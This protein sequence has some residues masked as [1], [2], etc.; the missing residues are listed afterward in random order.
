TVGQYGSDETFVVAQA[1]GHVGR[2]QQRL[3]EG[4]V[5][6]PALCRA[7]I[8]AQL[9]TEVLIGYALLGGELHCLA[10]PA[11]GLLGSKGAERR[12]ARPAGVVDRPGDVGWSGGGD[13]AA[14]HFADPG[15]WAFPVERFERL[16]DLAVQPRP[17]RGRGRATVLSR[18]GR[19]SPAR[20]DAAGAAPRRT[21]C[22]RSHG[23]APRPGR[24]SSRSGRGPRRTPSG[25][26]P[27]RRPAR[28]ARGARRPFP[29]GA[30]PAS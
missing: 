17:T 9:H 3:P 6:G 23:A 30:R 25:P 8:D 14:G 12:F 13:P 29:D 28:S 19:T 11:D 10:E 7:E 5:T 15:T 27:R 22:R 4:R 24:R 16:G 18:P 2:G 26:S 20:R 21:D 1:L